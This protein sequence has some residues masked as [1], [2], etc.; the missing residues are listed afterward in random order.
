MSERKILLVRKSEQNISNWSGGSTTELFIYPAGSSYKARDFEIRISSA[1][2]D[3]TPSTFTN[4]PGYH[5]VLMPLSAPLKLVFEEHGGAELAP[6]GTCE[7]EGEWNTVSHGLCTDIG[8]MLAAGW[9]G[10]LKAVGTGKHECPPGFSAVYALDDSVQVKADGQAHSLM[11]GD[12]LLLES[13]PAQIEIKTGRE[14]AAVLI[15]VSRK[16][17]P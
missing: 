16:A 2:V 12:F 15:Q 7:F 11:P 5:R 8:I 17:L 14:N 6:F 3:Q 1:T 10:S 13:P 4:L 9:Q